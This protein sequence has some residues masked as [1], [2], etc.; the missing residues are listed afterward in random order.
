MI[1]SKSA[2]NN[3]PS[4]FKRWLT[5][6]LLQRAASKQQMLAKRQKHERKRVKAGSKPVVEYFHQVDD[7]HSHLTL[8][9]LAPLKKQYDVEIVIHLVTAE[10]GANFPEPKLWQKLAVEDAENIAPY[11]NVSFPANSSIP[12]KP[13]CMLTAQILCNLSKQAFVD[14]GYQ[15]SQNLW[16]G[17]YHELQK[18]ADKYGLASEQE[19]KRRLEKGNRRRKKLQHFGGGNFY[20]EGEWY[21]KIDR[22]YHLEKRLK[23]LELHRKNH[24]A[25]IVLMQPVTSEFDKNSKTFTLEYFVSLRSPYSAISWQPT[26]EFVEQSGV[27]L[28]VRPVL[29]MVMRGV[30]AT[31]EKGKY[32]W[33]DA[34]READVRGA[35]FKQFYDPIGKPV[36]QGYSLYHW[37]EKSG[38]GNAVLNAFFKAAFVQGINLNTEAGLQRMIECTGLSWIEAKLHLNDEF[39]HHPLEDNRLT[40]YQSGKW[41]VPCYRLLDAE[42]NEIYFAWGQDRLWMVANKLK[43]ALS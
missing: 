1:N 23:A 17:K 36:L 18:A 29:P 12:L 5:S 2:S 10:E 32:F 43:E 25:D 39:W 13:Q 14:E 7:A 22:F 6:V 20:F 34:A 27:K 16:S 33:F 38:K 26:M 8:Q 41:G 42:G 9:L 31:Y 28:I 4:M 30:P 3:N 21:W 35:D 11:Y 15:I 37:A 19:L 40:M 24:H